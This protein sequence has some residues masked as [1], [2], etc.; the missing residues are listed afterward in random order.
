MIKIFGSSDD[1]IEVEGCTGANEF[2]AGGSGLVGGVI[3]LSSDLGIMKIYALYDGCWHFSVGLNDDGDTF[4]DWPISICRHKNGYSTVL[5]ILAP[6]N[7]V[8]SFYSDA[9]K[10]G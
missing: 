9:E 6:N 1:L 5:Q 3:Y 8:C 10:C 4:P 7:T 2:Y